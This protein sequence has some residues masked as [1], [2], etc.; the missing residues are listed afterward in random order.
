MTSATSTAK[1]E[2]V[3]YSLDDLRNDPG[4]RETWESLIHLGNPLNRAFAG[5][6]AFENHASMSQHERNRVAMIRDGE[7]QIIGVCPV[8]YW[9]LEM[10]LQARRRIFTKFK[11]RAATLHCGEPL[12]P[13]D[14][15]LFRVLFDGLLR[16]LTW[17]DC[18]Y[19]HSIPADCFTSRFIYGQF[20]QE[21]VRGQAFAYPRKLKPRR[22]IYHEPEQ[23]YEHFL[24]TK[25]KRTR[26]TFKRRVK[27]LR[28][29]GGGALTCER[30][31]RED[32]VDAFYEAA[33]SVAEKSWQF[34]TLGRALEETALH[35]PS[36]LSLAR[37]GGLRAYLL[38]CGDRPCAF[39]IGVQYDDV[40][41][42][43]QTAFSGDLALFSPGTVLY[44][45]LLEDVYAHRR[46]K[47][48]N[49]GT[50]VNPHKRLFS[51]RESLDTEIYLF[52][53]SIWNHLRATSHGLFYAGLEFAKRHARKPG[54]AGS[55]DGDDEDS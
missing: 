10:A 53:P 32:Q 25:N 17:C 40:L 13:Q 41:Q 48:L 52:R 12:L 33:Y 3:L 22:W 7:G 51:N 49:F 38:R 9:E 55:E 11:F 31:D 15:D 16:E 1:H 43:E 18:I 20:G 54:H 37:L 23:S 14:P 34:H 27:K 30:I 39:V 26:N 42:F 2:L 6:G 50:G 44:Y 46:P 24:Q 28:E 36:L 21:S 19:F 47:Y 4:L 8:E 5:P 29:Q 35:R 45:L